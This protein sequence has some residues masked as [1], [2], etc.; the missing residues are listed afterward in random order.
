MHWDL[1][2]PAPRRAPPSPPVFNN[3][4]GIACGASRPEVIVRVGVCSH[5]HLPGFNISY[6]LDSGK[7][8]QPPATQPAIGQQ[9]GRGPST[10]DIAVSADGAT[11]VWIPRGSPA[12]FTTD[13]GTTWTQSKGVPNNTRIIADSV[14]PNKFYGMSLF[15]G[16]LFL[17]SDGAVTFV[18][19]PFMLPGGLPTRGNARQD[20]GGGQ[21]HLYATPGREGDL[22]LGAS[23][24]LY[25]S[26][27]VGKPF[28]Q[29][30]GVT[31][32]HGFGFG[33]VAPGASAPA[34]YM[35]G[36]ANGVHGILRSDDWA[37]T[38]TRIND[39]QHQ[40]GLVTQVT[41]DPKLYGR[42]YVGTFG[43]GI[44]YGDPARKK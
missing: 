20:A 37:R 7:T 15:E 11:W 33:K 21:G 13:K 36:V 23:G 3:T 27:D 32:L 41:G 1:D 29:V 19:Q 40:W 9:G 14:N 30:D 25:H 28:Y 16:K 34:L 43:R 42:V 24:G 10:G 44:L 6:S 12:F 31:E 39:E 22:W 26:T 2:K 35:A 18:E 8:W 5:H 4:S 38:W 17:S